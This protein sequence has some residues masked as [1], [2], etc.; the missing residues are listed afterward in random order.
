MFNELLI[1]FLENK[2]IS[3]KKSQFRGKE[4][5]SWKRRNFVFSFLGA[6]YSRWPTF[7]LWKWKVKELALFHVLNTFR[8]ELPLKP[9]L[10]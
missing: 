10:F 4:E 8:F 6:R 1:L 9:A 3:G 2:I 7:C 5:I